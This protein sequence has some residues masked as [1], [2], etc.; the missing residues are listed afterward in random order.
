MFDAPEGFVPKRL[1]DQRVPMRDGVDL[2]ADIYLPPAGDGLWAVFGH[3]QSFLPWLVPV[4]A[5]LGVAMNIA[6]TLPDLENDLAGG[7][8]GLPTAWGYAGRWSPPGDCR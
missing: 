1:L 8:R 6:N 7:V 3:R 4:G 5:V 2:S